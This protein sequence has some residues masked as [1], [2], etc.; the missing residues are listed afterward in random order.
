[1]A[2]TIYINDDALIANLNSITGKLSN[3]I[4]GGT[5]RLFTAPTTVSKANVIGDFTEPSFLGY[6]AVALTVGTWGTPTV[7][8]HVGS[9]LYGASPSFTRSGT[10]SPVSI[11]GWFL[12]DASKTKLYACALFASGPYVLTNAGDAIAVNPTLT[13]QSLN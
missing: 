12:T 1:M 9:S 8:S 3:P 6:A 13:D 7:A 10:G 4:G 2:D 5:L 11:Y